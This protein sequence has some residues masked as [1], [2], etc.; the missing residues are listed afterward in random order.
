MDNLKMKSCSKCKLT[1]D[2]S[3]FVGVKNQETKQ[4]KKCRDTRKRYKQ[5]NKEKIKIKA[6]EYNKEYRQ[7]NKEEIKIKQREYRQKNKD[8]INAKRR[9]YCKKK[10]TC[11]CGRV[12]SYGHKSKHKYVSF[13]HI[14]YLKGVDEEKYKKF[15]KMHKDKYPEIAEKNIKYQKQKEEEDKMVKEWMELYYG[16]L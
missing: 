1:K 10:F 5:K 14:M 8:K 11:P 6:K 3:L 16:D 4:C 12:I 9:E 15:L 2:I 13:T 7:K